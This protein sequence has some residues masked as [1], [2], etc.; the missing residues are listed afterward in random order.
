MAFVFKKLL[1]EFDFA[2]LIFF[3]T[4]TMQ[5]NIYLLSANFF[6]GNKDSAIA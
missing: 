2:L 1:F 3:L 6:H 5:C 4:A